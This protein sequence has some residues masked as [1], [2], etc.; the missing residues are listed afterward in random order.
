MRRPVHARK[1]RGARA[2]RRAAPAQAALWKAEELPR[3]GVAPDATA[4][5][6]LR[7]HRSHGRVLALLREV[8]RHFPELDRVSLRVGLTRSAAGFAS[9]ED[10]IWLNPIRL[11]RHTIAHELVHLL[12]WRGLAPG[13]EMTAD[14]HALAR[15][16]SLVDDLPTYARTP[17]GFQRVWRA[18]DAELRGLLHVSAREALAA[19]PEHPRRVVR[20]FEREVES[21]WAVLWED[22]RGRGER[23]AGGETEQGRLFG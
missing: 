20:R 8:R 21:R 16:E 22:R 9:T 23:A 11:S 2:A 4:T 1:S 17:R 19:H 13:G 15:H 3:G 7:E 6:P 5:R 10:R 12:Q 18:G 14:I